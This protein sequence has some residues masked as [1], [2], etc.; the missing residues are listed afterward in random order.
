[1]SHQE[2]QRIFDEYAKSNSFDCWIGLQK[3]CDPIILKRHVFRVCDLVQ[4]EQQKRIAESARTRTNDESTSI[5]VDRSS[6]TNPE[7]LIK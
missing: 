5:I 6:I 7:N 2:K 3:S 1:M 4:E